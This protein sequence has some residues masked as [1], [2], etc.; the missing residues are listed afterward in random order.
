MRRRSAAVLAGLLLIMTGIW[1]TA[2]RAWAGGPT[3]VIIVSPTTGQAAALHTSNPRYQQLVEAVGAYDSPTGPTTPP[4]KVPADCFGCEIRLTWLIHDMSVWRIDRVYLTTDDG[5]WMASVSNSEGGDLNERTARWQRPH[6]A[7]ALLAL[8]DSSGV[9][10]EDS[11][12]APTDAAPTEPSPTGVAATNRA[13]T[14]PASTDAASTGNAGTPLGLV[15]L[16]SGT[17]G[18]LIGL[19]GSRLIRRRS[20]ADR[21]VLSD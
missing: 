4:A 6:D 3:S 19:I 11:S 21:V 13:P 17:V 16:G 10:A 20:R 15:A 12:P 2:G 8:L 14:N 9:T 5:I 7:K 18:V 1:S